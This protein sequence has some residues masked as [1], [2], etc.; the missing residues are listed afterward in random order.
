MAEPAPSLVMDVSV[1]VAA[2]SCDGPS[3]AI[4]QRERTLQLYLKWTMPLGVNTVC[5]YSI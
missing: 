4:I 2:N 5:K 3:V 1:C